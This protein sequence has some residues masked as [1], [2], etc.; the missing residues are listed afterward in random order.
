VRAKTIREFT[1]PLTFHCSCLARDS[2]SSQQQRGLAMCKGGVL[3]V[4]TFELLVTALYDG[5]TSQQ[6]SLLVTLVR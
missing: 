6:V 3:L 4:A 1:N 5:Y 2:C